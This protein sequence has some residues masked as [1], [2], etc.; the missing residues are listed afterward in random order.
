VIGLEMVRMAGESRG[1]SL[2]PSQRCVCSRVRLA[3]GLGFRVFQGWSCFEEASKIPDTFRSG[4]LPF[5]ER[6]TGG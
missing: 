6:L 3:I 4:V 2:F 1:L 5:V